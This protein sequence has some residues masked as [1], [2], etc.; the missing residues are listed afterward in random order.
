MAAGVAAVLGYGAAKI[1]DY[2]K[3]KKKENE[4]THVTEEEASEA[5]KKLVEALEADETDEELLEKEQGEPE[6]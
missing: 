5:R 4:V 2:I 1:V 6:K 3:N